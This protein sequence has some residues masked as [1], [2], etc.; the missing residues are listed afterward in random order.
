LA[1][2]RISALGRIFESIVVRVAVLND[3]VS[4][5]RVDQ[6]VFVPAGNIRTDAFDAA[7]EIAV[8]TYAARRGSFA[9]HEVIWIRIEFAVIAAGRNLRL[10]IMIA[11]KGEYGTTVAFLC[12]RQALARTT[13]AITRTEFA[14]RKV[15]PLAFAVADLNLCRFVYFFRFLIVRTTSLSARCTFAADDAIKVESPIFVRDIVLLA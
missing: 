2:S 4:A 11:V 14:V 10:S 3:I 8:I 1:K 12:F 5:N 13:T 6:F 15:A 9:I 7:K